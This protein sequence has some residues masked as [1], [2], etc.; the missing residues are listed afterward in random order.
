MDRSYRS[1]SG[2]GAQLHLAVPHHLDD[3]VVGS[4]RG[5][6][7]PTFHGNTEMQELVSS[8]GSKTSDRVV[9]AQNHV[10]VD[11]WCRDLPQPAP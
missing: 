3:G 4:L 7:A 9:V 5:T 6:G 8:G 11:A 2:Y 1:S 10:A